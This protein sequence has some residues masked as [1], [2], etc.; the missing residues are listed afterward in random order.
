MF[1]I[2][3]ERLGRLRVGRAKTAIHRV[4]KA[5]LLSQGRH[6]IRVEIEP[7]RGEVRRQSKSRHAKSRRGSLLVQ[8]Q[9]QSR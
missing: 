2:V 5:C 6:E 3:R 1:G 8:W 9:S 7:N 4:S